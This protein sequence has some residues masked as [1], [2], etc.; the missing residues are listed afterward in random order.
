MSAL[1]ERDPAA[2][3]NRPPVVPEPPAGSLADRIAARSR[4]LEQ[5]PERAIFVP[6]P[7]YEDIL[8][9]QYRALD[10]RE[11]LRIEKRHEKIK[12]TGEQYLL[13]A[14]G[15]LAAACEE[16]LEVVDQDTYRQTDPPGQKWN[17]GG[18]RALFSSRAAVRDLP[19]S[20]SVRQAM[21]AVFADEEALVQHA[22]DYEELRKSVRPGV[23]TALAGESEGGSTHKV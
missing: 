15:K 3:M 20:A 1:E 9:V 4:E 17:V 21:L 10:L 12:D 2:E 16:I 22:A 23:D 11:Q 14:V 7:G 13:V 8:V 18:V 6:V 19:D 5:E